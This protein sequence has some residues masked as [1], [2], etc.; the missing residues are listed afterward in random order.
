LAILNIPSTSAFY[1]VL[2]PLVKDPQPLTRSA[3]ITALGPASDPSL[4]ALQEIMAF[5]PRA[6][7]DSTVHRTLLTF[8][9]GLVVDM[10]ERQKGFK[11]GVQ[12]G[13]V[14]ILVESFVTL[15]QSASS[16]ETAMAREIAVSLVRTDV[17]H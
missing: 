7:E 11:G 9:T 14:R 4:R 15:L 2:Q 8:W 13:V 12:E 10:I 5:V 6:I 1:A 16:D 3:L 17:D